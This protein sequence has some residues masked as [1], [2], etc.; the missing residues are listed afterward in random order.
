[1]SSIVFWGA[2]PKDKAVSRHGHTQRRTECPGAPTGARAAHAGKPPGFGYNFLLISK[3]LRGFDAAR[4]GDAMP[5]YEYRC[6]S[7]GHELEALQKLS[8]PPL[9]DCPVCHKVDLRKLVS[10][11]GFQ[12]KG[13][14]WYVTDFRNSGAKPAAKDTGAKAAN[15]NGDAMA[16]DAKASDGKT[17]SAAAT[18]PAKPSGGE[19]GSSTTTTTKS[20]G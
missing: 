4:T 19:S 8:E 6:T 18:A 11:A 9:T 12:L 13:S 20:D 16:S 15:G 3:G 14:G 1:M 2:G 17:D 10:A 5:I 7:C